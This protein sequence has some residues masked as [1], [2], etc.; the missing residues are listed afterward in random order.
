MADRTIWV[1]RR[2]WPDSPHYGHEAIWLGEDAHGT[3][4][5]LTENRPVY[6]G[7]QILFVPVHRGLI[8][9]PEGEWWMAWF[10]IGRRFSLYVDI[11]TPPE[12]DGDSITMVDLDLDVIRTVDGVVELLDED[13]FAEHQVS[14][15]YPPEIIDAAVAS[16]ARV[17][18]AV[19]DHETPFVAPPSRWLEALTHLTAPDS[20]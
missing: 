8:V 9:V 19:R 17:F 16:G 3:W 4:L 20:P 6:R 12:R 18:A 13:E 1:E 2:K 7:D 5:G 15:G 10:P 14:L 11:V